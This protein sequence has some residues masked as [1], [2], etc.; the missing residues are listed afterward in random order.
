MSKQS[1]AKEGQGYS[2]EGPRCG[3]CRRFLSDSVPVKWMVEENDKRVEKGLTP[4]YD[5]TL[6]EHTKEANLRCG[7]GGFAVKKMGY[8]KRWEDENE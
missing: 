5:L 6:P 4:F 1:E 3:N 7:I 8:C 2:H